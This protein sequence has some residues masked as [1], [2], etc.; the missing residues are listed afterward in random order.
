MPVS[1]IAITKQTSQAGKNDPNMSKE[2]ALEQP[3]SN[4]E[5]SN[6]P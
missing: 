3:L 5:A 4:G 1:T 6:N 2:G